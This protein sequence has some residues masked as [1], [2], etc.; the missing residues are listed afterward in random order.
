MSLP[1]MNKLQPSKEQQVVLIRF[2]G[3]HSNDLFVF[4]AK[5]NYVMETNEMARL[6]A[7]GKYF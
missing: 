3:T 7:C 2:H 6:S 4:R 1:L 5:S